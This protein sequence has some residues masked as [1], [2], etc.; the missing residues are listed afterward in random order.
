MA[1]YMKRNTNYVI[2]SVMVQFLDKQGQVFEY[3]KTTFRVKPFCSKKENVPATI[4]KVINSQLSC[5][6]NTTYAKSKKIITISTNRGKF[7][8]TTNKNEMFFKTY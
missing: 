6:Q 4:V 8:L 5:D 1:N 2:N 3:G 7:I